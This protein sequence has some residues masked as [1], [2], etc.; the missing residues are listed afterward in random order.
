MRILVD[1]CVPSPLRRLIPNHECYTTQQQ[2][3]GG[4]KNGELLS[5][6]EAEFDLFITADQSLRYQQNLTNRKIAI[7]ELSVND[8]TRIQRAAGLIRAAV[9]K[10]QPGEFLRL[11][12]P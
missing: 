11:E 12:V 4:L 1:E 8:L 5:K 10:I 2:G 7:L 9:E 3:W 6:A